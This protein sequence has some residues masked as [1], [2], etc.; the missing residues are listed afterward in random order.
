MCASAARFSAIADFA[1]D[2]SALPDDLDNGPGADPLQETRDPV[3]LNRDA[4]GRRLETGTGEMEEDGAAASTHHRSAVP[5][6]VDHH[7]VEMIL[8]PHHLVA[9][10]AGQRHQGVVAP[11]A[12]VVAP[13]MPSLD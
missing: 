7:V 4:S 6:E 3:L 5:G 2:R 8:A 1:A 11:V 13:P 10:C 9:R 12:R